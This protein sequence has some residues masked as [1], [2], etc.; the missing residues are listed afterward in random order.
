MNLKRLIFIWLIIPLQLIAQ[1]SIDSLKSANNNDSNE[2][3]LFL[4][5]GDS[6]AN[7]SISL[8]EVL[9][10]EKLKFTDKQR[11]RQYHILKRKTRRAYP[12]AKMAAD[13]L[14]KVISSLKSIEKKRKQKKYIRHL[15]RFIEKQLTPELKKLTRT[16]GQILVKLI[17]RQTNVSMYDLVKE[18]RSGFKAYIYD[19][20]ANLFD[21]S[22]KEEFHPD[23]VYEDYLIEDI[24]QRSF[25]DDILEEQASAIN[26][27]LYALM[28]KWKF[29]FN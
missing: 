5:E 17:H 25:Q 13:T 18:Y 3:W 21:I 12:Y 23:R 7:E 9:I 16:E 6:I 28:D 2:K 11:L 4:I 27:D 1:T 22:L 26:Y 20:T 14:K 15:Q 10:L 24:L 19:K 29:L 8:N